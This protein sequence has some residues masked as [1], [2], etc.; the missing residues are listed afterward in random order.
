MSILEDILAELQTETCNYFRGG[1][2]RFYN[3]LE[4]LVEE[5]N[6]GAQ[7]LDLGGDVSDWLDRPE[8]QRQP[9]SFGHYFRKAGFEYS[10]LNWS[11]V[12]LCVDRLPFDDNVFDVV[13]S[14]ETI[15]HLW[16]FQAGGMLAWDG[17]L[18]FWHEA[19]RVLKPGGLFFV[20]TRNRFCPLIFERLRI[21]VFPQCYATGLVDGEF[22][23]GHIREFT[24]AELDGLA[25]VT[26]TY[27]ERKL[28][29]RSSLDPAHE[30]RLALVRADMEIFLRRTLSPDELADSIYLIGRKTG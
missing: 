4:T 19:H 5:A 6:P 29:C 12:D 2:R 21:G 14:W 20:A 26:G 1:W 13:T 16:T 22:R 10:S 23:G 27:P 3:T 7:V 9:Y 17:I 15:E 30:H 18:H 24:G 11:D 8:R 25:A 28:V